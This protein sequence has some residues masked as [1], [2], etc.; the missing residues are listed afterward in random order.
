MNE[1]ECDLLVKMAEMSSGAHGNT[2]EEV[3]I[4]NNGWKP[5]M[6]NA[7]IGQEFLAMEYRNSDRIIWDE[8]EVVGRL[9]KRVLQ[10]KE[11]SEDIGVLKGKEFEGLI[12]QGAVKRGE[13]WRSTGQGINE[14]MRFL[15]Y[16]SGQYFRGMFFL[17]ACF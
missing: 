3:E 4:E 16:G 8:K 9:W 1:S 15:R 11:V 7:G 14:R 5:A 12:G 17:L 10:V 6:V 13:T 2:G